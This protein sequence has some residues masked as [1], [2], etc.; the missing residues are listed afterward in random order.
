MYVYIYIQTL[1]IHV[2]FG[3]LV[4]P[5][6]HEKNGG[7]LSVVKVLPSGL[8]IQGYRWCSEGFVNP[9][10]RA[11]PYLSVHAVLSSSDILIYMCIQLHK[12]VFRYFHSYS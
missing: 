9:K 12:V 10:F 3:Q 5:N 2:S 6:G 7:N 8:T 11:A 4:P 1:F